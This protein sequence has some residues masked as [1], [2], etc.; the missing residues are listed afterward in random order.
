MIL[1]NGSYGILYLLYTDIQFFSQV[2]KGP[3]HQF[4]LKSF[5]FFDDSLG[6]TL[7]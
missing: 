7:G 5:F 2:Y 6:K 3:V 4:Y 1:F